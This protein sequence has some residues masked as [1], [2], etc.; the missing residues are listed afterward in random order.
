MT[1][2]SLPKHADFE[3]KGSPP[4][5][6][7]TEQITDKLVLHLAQGLR[8]RHTNEQKKNI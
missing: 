3:G 8:I 2:E 4:S 6:F 1:H 7:T 5:W